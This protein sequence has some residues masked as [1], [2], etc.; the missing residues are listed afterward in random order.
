MYIYYI[1]T[2]SS[3]GSSFTGCRLVGLAG[4]CAAPT[5]LAA[6]F[7]S[8]FVLVYQYSK[9]TEYQRSAR[10]QASVFVLLY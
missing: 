4:E 2:P 8:V 7:E 6:P 10:S 9:K 3:S 1:H 5:E